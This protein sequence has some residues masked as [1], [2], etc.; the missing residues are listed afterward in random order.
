M[1][2]YALGNGVRSL[3]LRVWGLG[4]WI[5]GLGFRTQ[6]LSSPKLTW[7][8]SKGL[9]YK[10]CYRFTCM[11]SPGERMCAQLNSKALL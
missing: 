11:G 4:F 6:V 7:K 3:A 1:R 9:R 2:F 5:W 8:P 10:E